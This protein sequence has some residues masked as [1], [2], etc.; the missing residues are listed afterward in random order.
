MYFS[1][2]GS[3]GLRVENRTFYRRFRTRPG[4]FPLKVSYKNLEVN[5]DVINYNEVIFIKNLNDVC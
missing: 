5:N 4:K 1:Y 2:G 3:M